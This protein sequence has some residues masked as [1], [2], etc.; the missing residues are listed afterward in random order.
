MNRFFV[1]LKEQKR[2]NMI[3]SGFS[4][5]TLCAKPALCTTLTTREMSLWASGSSSF[6]VRLP[7]D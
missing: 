7:L 2:K 5:A 3:P 1:D 4:L 6:K